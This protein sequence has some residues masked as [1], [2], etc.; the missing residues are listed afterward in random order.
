MVLTRIL[1]SYS[2]GSPPLTKFWTIS[3]LRCDSFSWVLFSNNIW[4]Q[5]WVKRSITQPHSRNTAHLFKKATVTLNLCFKY[6]VLQNLLFCHPSDILLKY[7]FIIKEYECFIYMYICV[8]HPYRAMWRPEVFLG[9][10]ET[11]KTDCW[12][13]PCG[14]WEVKRFSGR[15]ASMIN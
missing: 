3:S 5:K 7:L 9:S 4:H 13:L 8:P 10:P 14:C 1:H 2:F 11:G 15:A 6:I 12:E